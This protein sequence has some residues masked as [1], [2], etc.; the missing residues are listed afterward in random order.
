MYLHKLSSLVLAAFASIVLVAPSVSSTDQPR[1]DGQS[2][3]APVQRPVADG[4]APVPQLRMEERRFH[5]FL[6][7]NITRSFPLTV[8]PQFRRFQH[9]SHPRTWPL[10]EEHRCRQF[11]PCRSSRRWSPTAGH[12][13]LPFHQSGLPN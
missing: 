11:H 7:S 12:Q 1:H 13:F 10:M 3:A 2:P 9:R 6:I 8:G 5:L 4:G